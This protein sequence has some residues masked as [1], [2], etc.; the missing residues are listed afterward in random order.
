MVDSNDCICVEDIN[1]K[2][3]AHTFKY[4]TKV[5][6][7]A[8]GQFLKNIE[9]KLKREGKYFIK[10]SKWFPSSKTCSKC[11]TVKRELALSERTYTCDCC[12]ASLDR[13]INAAINIRMVGEK[14]IN[15]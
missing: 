7:G 6:E 5:K 4:G 10:I 3:M 2:N 14:L 9:Y 13:D 15:S 12:G 1:L 11:G 8:Y